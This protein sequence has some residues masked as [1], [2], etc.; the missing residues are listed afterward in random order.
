M[1]VVIADLKGRGGF[2][3]K[4][5]VVGGYGSRFSGFSWTTRWIERARK[6]YQNVPSIHAGYLAAIFAQAGHDVRIT[7]DAILEGDVALVLS[8]IVD[9]RHEVEWAEE[10]RQRFRMRVGFFGAPATHMPELLERHADFIIKGEPECAAMR[11]AA[12][13]IPKGLVESPPIPDL[14][15][16]PFPAWHLFHWKM[17]RH[18]VGRSLRPAHA[19]FPILSSRSCPEFCTYCPH[20]ITAPYRSRSPESVIA[21]IEDICARYSR[22][23]LVFRDPLFTQ[24]RVRS[25][26]IAEGI[27]R[28]NLPVQFECETRLD[29]LDK[30]LIDLLYRAGLRTITFGVESVDPATLKRVGRRPIP[31]GHQREIVAH[32][33]KKGISTEGFYVLGFLTDTPDSIRATVDYS[34]DLGTTLA[35][36]KILTPYPGT[37]LYKQMKPLITETDPERFDGYTPTFRHP[38]MSHEELKFTLGHAYTRFYLR[39][40][41]GLNYLG[42]ERARPNLLR[43]F[44]AYTH[45]R[46]FENEMAFFSSRV[47]KT[48]QQCFEQSRDTA[49][50]I[51]QVR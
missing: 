20:R 48:E 11:M 32:C 51:F 6:L 42:F 23:Y 17:V 38:S 19:A 40:S 50:G 27:I 41:W 3:N 24:E 25:T 4:D 22:A 33:R 34:I 8:S 37:P 31:P 1:R 39:P 7:R 26:A 21:E 36:F 5:T 49:H 30:D 35:L 29:D 14:D 45:R 12:G 28:K 9:H 10:A 44:E 47:S 15:T 2:V 46:H 13:E 18:A 16:L 43:R